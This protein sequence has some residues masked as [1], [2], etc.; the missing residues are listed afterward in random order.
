MRF[1][2]HMRIIPKDVKVLK[3]S[4]LQTGLSLYVLDF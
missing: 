1:A 4:Y 2:V 3:I